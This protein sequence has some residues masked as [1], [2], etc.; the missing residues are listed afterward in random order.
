M[1][2]VGLYLRST[3]AS[4]GS[5]AGNISFAA[6]A[7]YPHIGDLVGSIGMQQCPVHDSCSQVQ[8][9]AT[10]VV[11]LAVKRQHLALLGEAHLSATKQSA[12]SKAKECLGI[13]YARAVCYC[14][15]YG[16]SLQ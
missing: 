2:L 10:V 1:K 15:L 16:Y 11:Q 9:V 14:H 12:I 4:V 8:A 5:V 3:E 13:T 6:E 7:H